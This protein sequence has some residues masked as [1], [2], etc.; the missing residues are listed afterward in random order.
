MTA[1]EQPPV[2]TIGH[3]T[4]SI[5]EFVELLKVG[6]VR[7]VVDIRKTPRSRT[8]PQF[9]ID[10]L[11][12]WLSAWQIGYSRIEELGS[13]RTQ[14]KTVPPE[15]NGF[16]ANQSFHNYADYALSDEF[17]RCL[18]QLKQLSLERRCAIM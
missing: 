7:L 2:Y 13:R 10:A 17:R 5:A 11:P 12:E 8:N 4:R 6:S 9:N 18:S 16:W 14:S 15:V 1:T 3:S